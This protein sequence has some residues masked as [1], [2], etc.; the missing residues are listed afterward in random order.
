[1]RLI[2]WIHPRGSETL[3]TES[4]FDPPHFF[5]L[6]GPFTISTVYMYTILSNIPS[7]WNKSRILMCI[8]QF[9]SV[10][11]Q[12][13]ILCRNPERWWH[14]TNTN[15]LTNFRREEETWHLTLHTCDI[16]YST[17]A[18]SMA[19]G[20]IQPGWDMSR[21]Y[22]QPP[23]VHSKHK[24]EGPVSRE[25]IPSDNTHSN[26]RRFLQTGEWTPQTEHLLL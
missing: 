16:Q 22:K 19:P 11:T 7:C 13:I 20:Y 17:N 23:R 25:F 15:Y 5:L 6:A 2:S 12:I 9:H 14:G 3:W 1:M 21:F 26:M 24:P 18:V 10:V 4:N 8:W